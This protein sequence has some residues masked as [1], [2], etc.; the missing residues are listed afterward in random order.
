MVLNGVEMVLTSTG[1]VSTGK[2][3]SVLNGVETYC[4]N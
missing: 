1:I 3:E 4:Q 2:L